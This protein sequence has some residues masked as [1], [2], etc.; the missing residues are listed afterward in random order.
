LLDDHWPVTVAPAKAK[1]DLFAVGEGVGFQE[2][3]LLQLVVRSEPDAEDDVE[4]RVA[5]VS[6]PE[7][8][9][10]QAAE[11]DVG[12]QHCAECYG[13]LGRERLRKA[14]TES[15]S[16]RGCVCHAVRLS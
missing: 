10:G 12:M 3:E 1:A 13:V 14:R 6:L 16:G 5:V 15:R 2:H 7:A 4:H 9:R 8:V 11:V